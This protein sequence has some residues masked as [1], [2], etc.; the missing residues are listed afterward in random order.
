[1]CLFGVFWQEE[2]YT[3]NY[4]NARRWSVRVRAYMREGVGG[5]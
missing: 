2:P 5:S 3:D 1:M 4:T